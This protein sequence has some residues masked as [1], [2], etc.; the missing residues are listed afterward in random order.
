MLTGG[1][2]CGACRFECGGA[3]GAANY[4]HCS[5]CR[6]ATGSAFNIG[7]RLARTGLQMTRGAPRAFTKTGDSGRELS[8]HFCGDCGSPL[9]TSSPAHPEWIFVKAGV[10]DDPTVVAPE[11]ESWTSSEVAWARPP[12]GI[13]RYEKSRVA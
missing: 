2:L 9:F 11:S 4:C 3:V 10:L 5:D 12:A 13:A 8:R 7:V 1:C 6:R